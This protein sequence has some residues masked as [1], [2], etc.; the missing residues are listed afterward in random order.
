METIKAKLRDELEFV[1]DI[2][3]E[4]PRSEDE[5]GLLAFRDFILIYKLIRIY[6]HP[7]RHRELQELKTK[8]RHALKKNDDQLYKVIVEQQTE[9]ED[10]IYDEITSVV[11]DRFDFSQ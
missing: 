2:H 1:G 7:S 10:E 5:E 6:T 4:P 3:P 11:F 8:R 9:R